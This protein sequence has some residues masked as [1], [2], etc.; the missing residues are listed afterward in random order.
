MHQPAIWLFIHWMSWILA[1]DAFVTFEIVVVS[2]IAKWRGATAQLWRSSGDRFQVGQV[3][4]SSPVLAAGCR[5]PRTAVFGCIQVVPDHRDRSQ[6][7]EA[8]LQTEIWGLIL[9]GKILIGEDVS[10]ILSCCFIS[11]LF[12]WIFGMADG[13]ESISAM[14]TFSFVCVCACDCVFELGC[15][16]P[17]LECFWSLSSWPSTKTRPLGQQF[18]GSG[19]VVEEWPGYFLVPC[20]WQNIFF[21]HTHTIL[22]Y[23][24]TFFMNKYMRIHMYVICI[25]LYVCILIDVWSWFVSGLL[26]LKQRWGFVACSG[27]KNKFKMQYAYRPY[28]S[29]SS[30]SS[31]H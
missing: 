16:S 7:R 19:Y 21:P 15:T 11:T 13:H 28:S 22:F 3:S 24:L 1:F 2:G 17:S 31:H 8:L 9:M 5:A 20:A 23:I 25:M 12:L 30:A 14:F 18:W 10:R 4:P 26:P 27:S 29:T 6:R